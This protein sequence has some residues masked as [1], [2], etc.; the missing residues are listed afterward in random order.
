[1]AEYVSFSQ[2]T[3]LLLTWEHGIHFDGSV[4]D[5]TRIYCMCSAVCSFAPHSQAAV[6][7]ITHLFV[8][9]KIRKMSIRRRLSLT[10][11][12]LGK[13]NPGSVGLTSLINV[14]SRELFFR[15]SMLLLYSAHR[16]TLTPDWTGSFSRS[17]VAGASRCLDLSCRSCS[18][19]GDMCLLCRRYSGF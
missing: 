6:K 16:A 13:L 19:S 17:S 15:H 18:L 12:D 2:I 3:R 5:R 1:M 10:R 14:W 8:S 4:I 11:A 9:E 7:S